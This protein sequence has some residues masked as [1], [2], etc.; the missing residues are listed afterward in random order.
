MSKRLDLVT[1]EILKKLFCTGILNK[2]TGARNL[3]GVGLS[4]RPARLHRLAE[5]IPLNRFLGS[6]KVHKHEIF[7]NF[8]FT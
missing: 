7:L 6:L 1:D 5:L 2:S 8:F 3:V 4:Y